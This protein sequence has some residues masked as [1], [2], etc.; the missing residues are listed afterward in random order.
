MRIAMFMPGLGP[1]SL[2][3]QG[4]LDFAQ[5]MRD[6]GHPFAM[7]VTPGAGGSAA[8]AEQA[9]VRVSHWRPS[10]TASSRRSAVRIP[11]PNR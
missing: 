5:A 11:R 10:W 6:A 9:R 8:P 2:G 4:H 3:W 7:L 1:R